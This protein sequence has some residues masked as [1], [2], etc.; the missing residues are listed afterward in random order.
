MSPLSDT[1]LWSSPER[2]TPEH[3]QWSA[4]TSVASTSQ[5]SNE[6]AKS[7][8]RPKH[9]TTSV[10][11]PKSCDFYSAYTHIYAPITIDSSS[12]D[13]EEVEKLSEKDSDG[14]DGLTAAD[15]VSN[16]AQSLKKNILLQI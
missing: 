6:Q 3:R 8:T 13:L 10:G 12:S 4:T 7:A 16:L 2:S 11:E 14:H 15:I 5:S 9:T 1:V